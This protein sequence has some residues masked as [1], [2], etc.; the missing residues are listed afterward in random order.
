MATRVCQTRLSGAA[1]LTSLLHLR[2][3]QVKLLEAHVRQGVSQLRA[4]KELSE[5][6]QRSLAEAGGGA[7]EG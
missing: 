5:V 6:A 2:A 4:A 3:G 7:W 1:F